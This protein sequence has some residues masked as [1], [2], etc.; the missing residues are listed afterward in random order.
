M[1][2]ATV[3]GK[4]HALR[5]TQ[6]LTE[7]F[8]VE[9]YPE[10]EPSAVKVS[11]PYKNWPVPITMKVR[12]DTREDALLCV[13]EHLKKLGKISDFQLDEADR[14]KPPPPVE[15]KAPAAASPAKSEKPEAPAA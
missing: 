3:N 6:D 15:P 5:V 7:N 9:V 10:P 2:Y 12:A 14:P 8:A 13:L 11:E 4:R 1:S